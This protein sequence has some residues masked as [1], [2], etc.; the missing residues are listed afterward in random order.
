M[1][2]AFDHQTTTTDF[3]TKQPYCLITSDPGTGKTRSVLDAFVKLKKKRSKLLVMEH[4]LKKRSRLLVLAPLSI[5]QASWGDDIEKFTPELTYSIAIASNRKK[6]F[7]QDTD[8]TITNHDAIKWLLANPE[9]VSN[10]SMLCIDEFTA[11]KN[12]NS[13]RTKALLKVTR[14]N[15]KRREPKQNAST[16]WESIIAMSGT[17]NSNTICDIWAPALIVDGGTR[18]GKRFHSFQAQVC[19]SHWNGFGNEWKDKE[20][21]ELM[22]AAAL[23]DINIRYKLEDCIDMPEKSMRT[24]YID[25]P[26]EI[27]QQYNELEESSVLY[28]GEETVNAIHAGARVKKLLQLCTGAVYVPDG[29]GATKIVGI[30]KQ[31][32]D[33]VMSL[34]A[35]RKHS[36]VAFNWRHEKEYLVEEAKKQKI[37]Y[38]VID[39]SVP[40]KKRTEAVARFQAGQLQVL[41]CHP[42]A[43]GHGLTLTKAN[44]IIWAS[45]TYNAEHFEQFNGRIYRAG[46]KQKVEI[47]LIA[48][49]HTWEPT[50]Y[51]K[52]TIKL[53]RMEELLNILKELRKANE[54]N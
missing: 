4:I 6:A 29:E 22:V 50:V 32:Y 49:R 36:L 5:L 15:I 44:T 3:I 14:P 9:F 24:M 35:A 23:K 2:K 1:L 43:A 34:V 25:L 46:Q 42:Q 54:N 51:E 11:F 8:V 18:L 48:A 52:L 28:T 45:P 13:A 40:S 7:Q 37:S 31:R 47:I 27:Q 30:H 19:T 21:A 41:F 53:A 20:G 38:A 17:P 33:L 26:S 16:S 12:A 39:G 10:Y